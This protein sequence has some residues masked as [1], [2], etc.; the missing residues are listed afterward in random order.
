MEDVRKTRIR[1]AEVRTTMCR[2]I[3]T[4]DEIN[5]RRKKKEKIVILKTKQ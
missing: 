3:N 4:R 5:S 1:L 2:N